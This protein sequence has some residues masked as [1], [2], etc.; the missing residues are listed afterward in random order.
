[1]KLWH[2]IRQELSA[3]AALLPLMWASSR[4]PWLGAFY[5]SDASPCGKGACME[6]PGPLVVSSTGRVAEKWR[7]RVSEAISAWAHA[8]E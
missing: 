5:A 8:F 1:M 6:K 3:V 2:S 7:H 4:V